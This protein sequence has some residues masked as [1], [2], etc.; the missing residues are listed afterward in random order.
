MSNI[1]AID[2]SPTHSGIAISKSGVPYTLATIKPPKIEKDVHYLKYIQKT[3]IFYLEEYKIDT[4]IREDYAYAATY[5]AHQMGELG[6]AIKLL[7]YEKKLLCISMPIG[8]HKK[9][10]TGKG[11][12]KKDLMIKAVYKAYGVDVDDHNIADAVSMLKTYMGYLKPE[13]LNIKQSEAL[14][15]LGPIVEEANSVLRR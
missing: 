6:G 9:F 8:V 15:T 1:L 13:G 14:K 10:T 7:A 4:I 5:Y 2:Q 3:L 12:A 11:N